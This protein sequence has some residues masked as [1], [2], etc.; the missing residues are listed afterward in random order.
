MSSN[1]FSYSLINP[2]SVVLDKPSKDFQRGDFLKVIKKKNIERITF[3]YTA[4]DGR[5]KEL[6]LPVT[7]SHNTELILAE[8]ERVDGSS[9]FKGIIDNDVSDLYVMPEYKTAFLNPF[10]KGSLDFIC[11]YLTKDGERACFAPDNIL[12][13]S[14]KL[15]H[16]NTELELYALGELEFYLV[17]DK[18]QNL[19]S[20]LPQEA[21]HESAPFRKNGDILN[22]IIRLT[23]EI[24]G[25]VK[26]AHSEVGFIETI[27]S[28]IEQINGKQAE[29]LELEF[30]TKSIEEMADALVVGRWI[31]RNVAYQHGCLATFV[32]KLD[33]NAAGNGLHVHLELKKD[34]KNIMRNMDGKLS[35]EAI[36]L[37]GGLCKYADSL[38]AFG[39]TV[40]SS[41][42][43]LV[44]DQEAPTRI[45]CS[46]LN[47]SALIRIP[48][49]WS[50][51]YDLARV[52]NPHE[53][54][55]FEGARRRQTV[56][57]RSPDGSSLVHLLLA[58]MTM[59]AE[60]AFKESNSL[61]LAE[62]FYVK[63]N[64]VQD[65]ENISDFP[66]LPASC[67]ES[68]KVLLEKR[69]LYERERIFPSSVIEYIVNLLKKENYDL[70]GYERL[71]EIKRI[72][73]K[74][75]YC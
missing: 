46:E 44:P 47:R 37:I 34:G 3:H 70:K 2:I 36:R 27:E 16:V 42:L 7:S 68:S 35:E 50:N 66:M 54:S 52:V 26:Y 48:L 51:V 55:I 41:Y 57:L 9:L 74:D 10:D 71:D 45:Y 73:H 6:K 33:E 4:M 39:N 25:A 1:N 38:T 65:E 32:P 15:F 61:K 59:S 28:E 49:G 40:T 13:K 18:G 12:A 21:Y 60:W 8:G 23:S 5:L 75:L 29:Q 62:K 58:G 31:I 64:S 11:R 63:G 69:E 19:Y 67:V 56:E 14:Y 43:R 53:E 17:R 22:E 20:I 30:S 72:M 24:T